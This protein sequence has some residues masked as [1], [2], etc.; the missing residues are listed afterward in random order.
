MDPAANMKNQ[1]E[2]ARDILAQF[3]QHD[4]EDLDAQ[5]I[6]DFAHDAGRLAELV[7][8][9]DTWTRYYFAPEAKIRFWKH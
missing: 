6:R 3:E 1:L 9:L 7:I 8:T 4:I 2:L 5:S